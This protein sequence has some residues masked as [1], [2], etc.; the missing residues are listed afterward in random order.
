MDVGEAA[1]NI[2]VAIGLDLAKKLCFGQQ[3]ELVTDQTLKVDK[4]NKALGGLQI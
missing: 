2:R 1:K 4:N 3:H